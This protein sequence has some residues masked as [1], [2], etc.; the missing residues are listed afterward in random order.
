MALLAYSIFLLYSNLPVDTQPQVFEKTNYSSVNTNPS[1]LGKKMQF[2]PNMRFNHLPIT[3]NIDPLCSEEK[4]KNM[5]DAMNLLTEKADLY[6]KQLNEENKADII[7]ACGE[8]YHEEGKSLFTA[9]EGGPTL[10]VNTT[11]YSVIVKGKVQLYSSDKCG[12]NVEL[13][14]LLHVFGFDHSSNDESIMYPVTSCEQRLTNDIIKELKRLYEKEPK[15]DLHFLDAEAMKKLRYLDIKIKVMNQGIINATNVKVLLSSQGTRIE[16]F[17]FG[18]IGFGASKIITVQNLR[19]PSRS[20][21]KL[22][23]SIDPEDKID[24]YNEN[25]NYV[26]MS[27]G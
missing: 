12:Y 16:E 21:E 11:S 22:E 13:H 2:Y 25:N 1:Y 9:G 8:K 5:M 19:L 26:E 20:I 23:I 15:A 4:K 18:D 24:E 6:F 7:I 17:D 10:V 14:E 27:V 3:Y